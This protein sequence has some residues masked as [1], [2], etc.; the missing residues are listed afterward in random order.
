MPDVEWEGTLLCASSNCRVMA[1]VN[2]SFNK[3]NGGAFLSKQA[4][5]PSKFLHV[6]RGR[7]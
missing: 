5:P 2:K 3:F 7:R 4:A 6:S 1:W